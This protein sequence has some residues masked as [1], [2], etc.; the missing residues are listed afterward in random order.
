MVAD[1]GFLKVP[2]Q[3]TEGERHEAVAD[4]LA[5]EEPLEIRLG[6][7]SAKLRQQRSV[8]VTMRTPGHDAEL[9]AGFLLSEAIVR[10]AE[11]IVFIRPCGPAHG[12]QQTPNVIRVELR[13]DLEFDLGR[14]ERHFYTTSSCGVCGKT[15]LAALE[16]GHA[17]PL[18]HDAPKVTAD[19]IHRL[20]GQL[21]AAQEV[22]DQTG[23]LHAAG[24]FDA[25][26]RI[27][28]VRE[29]VGRHNA[30]DKLIGAQLIAGQTP[31]VNRGIIVSGRASFELLQKAL[32]GGIA[33]LV[34]VGAPST[35]AVQLAE[36]FDMTLVGFAREGKFNT[37]C[38]AWRIG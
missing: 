19:A 24:L 37:Y 32:M 20:P 3:R 25:E 6:Y 1:L 27:H 21:R 4:Q 16:T 8:A 35:L 26:G 23:G 18:S 14:L 29:D 5:I 12:A 7:G 17:P 9:A 2:I 28:S 34:A 13:D 38:G 11:D 36:K 15:S 31:L 10:C 33:F 22:F 30:V